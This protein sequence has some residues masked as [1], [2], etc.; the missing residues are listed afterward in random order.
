MQTRATDRR[1]GAWRGSQK[2]GTFFPPPAQPL[3]RRKLTLLLTQRFFPALKWPARLRPYNIPTS[4]ILFFI[5]ALDPHSGNAFNPLPVLRTIPSYVKLW[6]RLQAITGE[7]AA[8]TSDAEELSSMLSSL[9]LSARS[10]QMESAH[11]Q[12]LA[13]SVLGELDLT[14]EH[15]ERAEEK[16]K[17][18]TRVAEAESKATAADEAAAVAS[19]QVEALQKR[20]DE[21]EHERGRMDLDVSEASEQVEDAKRGPLSSFCFTPL[22]THTLVRAAAT[23]TR[24]QLATAQRT[25]ED[26]QR[27]LAS[28]QTE[29]GLVKRENGRLEGLLRALRNDMDKA[30]GRVKEIEQ[31][32]ADSA[33]EKETLQELLRKARKAADDAGALLSLAPFPLTAR[34][35][36]RDLGT[37]RAVETVP[38]ST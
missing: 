27:R 29:I 25:A 11:R 21:L 13:S 30:E 19:D 38:T 28:V 3:G 22:R 17:L 2:R 26:A 37:P 12:G 34:V 36:R 24:T 4:H 18:L 1:R 14:Q 15:K 23:T 35:P 9:E 16:I 8:G 20:V 32:L 7:T 10:T 33:Q 5:S 6:R 31:V